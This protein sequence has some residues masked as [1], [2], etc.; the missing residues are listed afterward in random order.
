[1]KI[2]H[3]LF[4]WLCF[5][6]VGALNAQ[7]NDDFSDGDFT[8]NPA[9]TGN[10][11]DFVVNSNFEL[12]SNGPNV[13]STLYL[14][15]PNSLIDSALWRF[16]VKLTFNPSTANY[17]RIYLVSDQQDLSASLN[18]YFV[19]FGETGN[20]DTIMIYRQTGA[21]NTLVYKGSKNCMN[22]TTLND[23]LV[24]IT[25]DNAGNWR[26]YTDC[27]GGS[28]PT[29]EGTF[30]DNTHTTTAHFGVYCRYSTTSRRD[31]FYFDDF[32]IEPYLG[33]SIPPQ[34][35]NLQVVGNNRLHV[36]FDEPIQAVDL[37]NIQNFS[38]NQFIG[39]PIS[40]SILNSN[41]VE[42]TFADTFEINLNYILTVS[43]IRDL[44]GNTLS[45][46]TRNFARIVSI[47][48]DY[49]DI[50]INEILPDENPS[51][52][53]P[54][55]EYVELHNRSNKSIAL[56][57]WKFASRTT[58]GN[59]PNLLL[60]PGEFVVLHSNSA[61]ALFASVPN[62]IGISP[63]PTLRNSDD[64]L[65]LRDDQNNMVDYV[66]YDISWYKDNAKSD[67]G[68][69][70]ELIN[71]QALCSGQ[72]NWRASENPLGGTPGFQNSVLD[73]SPDTEAPKLLNAFMLSPLSLNLIFD[74]PLDTTTV[75]L[76]NFVA[77]PSIGIQQVDFSDDLSQ[78]TV[79]FAQSVDTGV[80][81]T[82][83]I[84][85]ISDCAGNTFNGNTPFA[86][87]KEAEPY[88][89]II[90]EIHHIPNEE[91][92][93][94]TRFE[95]VELYNRGTKA[96][97]LNGLQF[98]D[99][100]SRANLPAG[101]I[102]PGEHLI[103]CSN[104]GVNDLR[105]FGRTIGI[106]PWPTL[107][108]AGDRL[109]L[110][111][112]SVYIHA[113]NY[114][115]DWHTDS[116][117]RTGGYS[118]ELIDPT[119]PCWEAENWKSSDDSKGGT[120]G[121]QNSVFDAGA[122]AQQ[123]RFAS[124][125]L[126]DS[127]TLSFRFTQRMDSFYFA[128]NPPVISGY[129]VDNIESDRRFSQRFDVRYTPQL[130]AGDVFQIQ[131]PTQR[132][133]KQETAEAVQE[134]IKWPSPGDVVVNELLFNPR[135]GGSDF[136]EFYNRSEYN[137]ELSGWALAYTNTAG[138]TLYRPL[139]ETSVRLAP[140]GYRVFTPSPE[141]IVLEYARAIDS[142]IHATTLPTYANASGVATLVSPF[143]EVI[144]RFVYDDKMHFPL[145][146]DVKGVSL[147]R[148]NPNRPSSERSNWHSA[149]EAENF[150]TPGYQNSQFMR[151]NPADE[152]VVLYPETFSP[153]NDGV[154]DQLF[155]QFKF[156]Q[157]GYVANVRIF[158]PSGR[159]IKK[160]LNNVL[161]GTESTFSW[162]GIDEN[163]EKCR[164]GIYVVFC[165]VFDLNGDVKQYKKACVLATRF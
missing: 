88:E 137:I 100:S 62:A 28:N 140:G 160:L 118:L 99:P 149:S 81:Y 13:T 4:I 85:N 138:D 159:E 32:V 151:P 83:N 33:D 14:S 109:L 17:P 80:V 69:S 73:L 24:T 19:L 147:E 155:I 161:L 135:T 49:R 74:E 6:S 144:D 22:S 66:A 95:Y 12:Q 31:M 97:S 63:W 37:Q 127:N 111:K 123:A 91:L 44:A 2:K 93:Q 139:S 153:D 150:A 65:E 136:I 103:L 129:S 43:N 152:E 72:N 154:D 51:I 9:W 35:T 26:V 148:V 16:R 45:S 105:N 108:I 96:V 114:S 162:D 163:G 82:L 10:V 165:E 3:I 101:V 142:L 55:A 115:R 59:I 122:L 120:P 23:V 60:Q 124:A 68:W 89:I 30:T 79:T 121:Q 38:V 53:L 128:Q 94:I 21:T 61:S 42:L 36:T 157:P 145:L 56:L 119:N 78:L 90:N 156:D 20:D 134:I 76:Q 50:I 87:G 57:G 146:R 64:Q 39:Q 132:N 112:D 67:G 77:T 130:K 84:S 58:S 7:L 15:T 102:L 5:F 92:S 158:D 48:V 54:Q 133:C 34:I 116:E 8:S 110:S 75:I 125:S 52:G 27:S 106:S 47:P 46:A 1:M 40:A 98:S 126:L 11:A 131:V 141:N 107:N 29:L 70:L 164:V 86:W 104:S 113:V 143:K 41:A 25:R 71:P 117:R 18:G